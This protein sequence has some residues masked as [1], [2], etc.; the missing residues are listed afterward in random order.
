MEDS[1]GMLDAVGGLPEQLAD[2]LDAAGAVALPAGWG[3]DAFDHVVVAGMG[4]SGIAGDVLA[5][6]AGAVLAVPLT[7]VKHPA[8]PAFVGAR[9]LVFALSY[10]GGTEETVQ[11]ASEAMDAGASVV[12]VTCGGDLGALAEARGA[13]IVPCRPGLMPRAALGSLLAPLLVVL[14]RVGILPGATAMVAAARDQLV[15]RR[16]QCRPEIEATANP[17]RDL[18]RRLERTIPLVYGAGPIGAVAAYRWKC[19]VNENA[20]APAFW[21]VYP[22]LTHNEICGWGQHGDVTRQIVSLVQLR[23]AFETPRL[24]ARVDAATVIVDEALHQVLTVEAEGDG[25]LAQLLDLMY[26][27]D[28]VSCYLALDNDVDPGPIPAIAELKRQLAAP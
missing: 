10:S 11:A 18:A 28:W 7:V 17:A 15:A 21:N 24:A 27:G 12:V 16:N 6:A 26:L 25:P 4:G 8:L 2:A 5:A 23:H 19:D 3:A 22:E 20:K 9:T 13:T 14:E 1:L